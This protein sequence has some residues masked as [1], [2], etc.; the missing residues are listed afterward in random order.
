MLPRACAHGDGRIAVLFARRLVVALATL[1]SAVLARG[2][3]W[4]LMAPTADVV[5]FQHGKPDQ[6]RV[7]RCGGGV[8]EYGMEIA[9]WPCLVWMYDGKGKIF[10][11]APGNKVAPAFK[12]VGCNTPTPRVVATD[13]PVWQINSCTN[14]VGKTVPCNSIGLGIDS[15]DD[16][17]PPADEADGTFNW[18]LGLTR[19]CSTRTEAVAAA[20]ECAAR[21]AVPAT[22]PARL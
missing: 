16:Y 8:D 13:K 1:F 22:P 15:E 12:V 4:P 5:Q 9:P 3:C 2:E 7:A 17:T 19:V 18:L 21:D 6:H 10:F 20:K 11:E 14:T